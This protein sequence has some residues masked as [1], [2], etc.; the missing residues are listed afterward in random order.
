MRLIRLLTAVVAGAATLVLPRR[1]P[2]RLRL[3]RARGGM[4]PGGRGMTAPYLTALG[5]A[6]PAEL[7]A[8]GGRG[9]RARAWAPPRSDGKIYYLY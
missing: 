9:G 2:G 8:E 6:A 3:D 1:R 7:A 4:P 5:A